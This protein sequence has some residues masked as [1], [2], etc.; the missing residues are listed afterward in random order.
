[1]VELLFLLYQDNA[2]CLYENLKCSMKTLNLGLFIFLFSFISCGQPEK[3]A[4]KEEESAQSNPKNVGIYPKFEGKTG[5]ISISGTVPS[6][7][8][9]W[10]HLYETEGK[11]YF[12][13]DSARLEDGQFK[14][15]LNNI[16]P[17]LFKIGFSDDQTKL[18][19][20]ILNPSEERIE[21]NYSSSN[22]Q[23]GLSNTDSEENKALNEYEKE[24]RK[25]NNKVRQIRQSREQGLNKR[26]AIYDEQAEFKA[27]QDKVA[28]E[29]ESTFFANMVRHL[30]SPNRF[31]KN[32]YWKDMDYGD[33][34][35]IHS[36]VWPDRI[37]DYMR[38][39]ASKE[40][41]KEEPRLGFYNAV[42]MLA[43]EIMQDGNDEVL[44]FVLYTLS[45]GF[46]SSNMES[47]SLYV[48][49]NYFYGDACGDAEISELFK[50]KAAGIRKLQVGNTPPDFTLPNSK[51]STTRFSSVAEENELTLVLFWASFCHKCEREIP[52]IK[53]V[54]DQYK[55]QGF[56]ILAVSVDT[57]KSEWID[58]IKSHGTNWPNVSDLEGWRSP[59]SKDFRVS[60]TPVM[61]LVNQERE[62][63][64]KPKNVSEL[65]R[66]LS[67]RLS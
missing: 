21:L 38:L 33:E 23:Y 25:H 22:F 16:S 8:N 14:M 34:S 61:F 31:D 56:E 43:T 12:L 47:L 55:A 13:I 67:K 59:V 48:V 17:G 4:N 24:E 26:Q 46:Y 18:G 41:S 20:V 27:Y 19:D 30:Q 44:E 6:E 62:I 28:T 5:S 45:E 60:S 11:D 1:M 63:I 2:I 51:G 40:K 15:K 54:Y 29:Y 35:L 50:M 32:K 49:D 64:A 39:H 37:T 57:D 52:E 7:D 58:G 42:D 3:Q 53:S 65:K 36:P 9:R 66:A 10:L